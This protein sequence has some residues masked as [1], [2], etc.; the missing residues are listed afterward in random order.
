M[1]KRSRVLTPVEDKLIGMD[2]NMVELGGDLVTFLARNLE[3]NK[4]PFHLEHDGTHSQVKCLNAISWMESG[5]YSCTSGQTG[6]E[7][8]AVSTHTLELITDRQHKR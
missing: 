4:D 2:F 1:S 5:V 7:P 3:V 6:C 8:R